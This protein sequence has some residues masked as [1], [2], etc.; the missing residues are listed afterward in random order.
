MIGVWH[1]DRHQC[2][3]V[4]LPNVHHNGLTACV[5]GEVWWRGNVGVWRSRQLRRLV[6]WTAAGK[7]VHETTGWD[8]YFLH[9][10]GCDDTAVN[11]SPEHRCVEAEELTAAE[12]W[13]VRS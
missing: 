3:D 13:A 5:C 4:H 9:A 10:A 1:A 12:V 7:P 6:E 2:G 8:R 11:P